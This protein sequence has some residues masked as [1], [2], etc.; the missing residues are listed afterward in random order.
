MS[1][2]TLAARYRSSGI[3]LSTG[4]TFT[5]ATE[6]SY[7]TGAPS[8]G[9]FLSWAAVNA[10][11]LENRGDG[12]GTML[13][14]EGPRTNRI[15]QSRDITNAAA[16]AVASSGATVTGDAGNGPDG[17]AVADRVQA[18]GSQWSKGQMLTS[19]NAQVLSAYA[20][21][22]SG[23]SEWR[24]NFNGA[25]AWTGSVSTT[26]TRKDHAYASLTA[27]YHPVDSSL[28]GTAEDVLVDLHQ[29]EDGV[30]P[31][32]PIRT[33]VSSVTRAADL[34]SF[35]VGQYPASFLTSGFRVT[36]APDCSSAELLSSGL[37]H[38]LLGFLNSQNFAII[39]INGGAIKVRI[40]AQNTEKVLGNAL[41]FSRGTLL[42]VD[43]IPSTGTIIVSGAAAG[44][45]TTVG[46]PFS[47]SSGTLHVGSLAGVSEFAF[48]RFGTTIEAL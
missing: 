33:T 20:R 13:L 2:T 43:V 9:T 23:A 36:Y 11:R 21:G 19:P 35:A 48:G 10:R 30:F 29:M 15:L 3:G 18:S 28:G 40:A 42:T 32:S 12:L 24:S 41:T 27:G 47:F 16:W 1:R 17:S 6:G 34:L 25:A 8:S 26:W 46:T 37:Q 14:M 39:A 31:S 4:G 7:L 5:R 38:N 45:G 22:T 44:N